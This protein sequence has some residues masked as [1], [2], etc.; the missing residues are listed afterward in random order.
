M[1]A[2][3]SPA[4]V[5]ALL[6]AAFLLLLPAPPAAAEEA[7]PARSIDRIAAGPE[8]LRIRL[9]GGNDRERF[10]LVALH[11]WEPDDAV[12]TLVHAG[13][14]GEET[15]EIPRRLGD[16]DLLFS[17]FLV[18]GDRRRPARWATSLEPPAEGT[19]I[20]WPAARKGVAVPD[21]IDDAVELGSA[22][23]T[24]NVELGSLLL[25]PGAED[26]PAAFI[27]N[28]DG[29]RLRFDPATVRHWDEQ[30]GEMT[31]R[32]LHVT[33]VFLNQLQK[34]AAAK[35]V[36]HP[37]TNVEEALFDLGA[38]NLTDARGVASYTAVL[39]FLAE[40][41]SRADRRYGH[42]GGYIVGNEID[43]HWT[44]HNMGEADLAAVARQ[45]ERE[46]RLAWLAVREHAPGA[47]VFTS[48][49]HSWSRPNARAPLRNTAGREL[50][51]ALTRLSRAGGDFDW[52]IAHHPYPQNLFDPRFWDDQLAMFGFD[53]P[54]ITFANLEL[55]PAFLARPEMLCNG[56][57]RRVI[58]SE[59]GFHTLP[60]VEGERL[61]AAALALAAYRIF[62]IDGIDAFILHRHAD[63]AG[64]G[65]LLLGLRHLAPAP[66]ELGPKKLAWDVFR[67]MET[68]AF[69]SSAAFA[70]PYAGHERW[71]EA[72]PRPGPFPEHAPEWAGFKRR[73]APLVD[74]TAAADQARF[75][76]DLDHGVKL[77]SLPDGGM[78][79][80]LYL[81]PNTPDGPAAAAV[82]AVDLGD[83]EAPE[84]AFSPY[85]AK[86]GSDGVLFRVR[87]DGEELLAA[88][89]RFGSMQEQRVDLSAFAG[90]RV[91]L[92]LETEPGATSAYDEAYF[93]SPAV[94]RGRRSD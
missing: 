23:V 81:H 73:E 10:R 34:V 83:A 13:P 18:E 17:R 85:V 5:A 11:A 8:T 58:L 64:E 80:A 78:A 66:G 49:T 3:V 76:N 31:R 72:A 1:H 48:L 36:I 47:R 59:Q 40:R 6:I 92:R 79:D 93:V 7:A 45:H 51:E 2:D 55:L 52:D 29:Q 20:R 86:P 37:A 39:G 57:P 27:V 30:I 19:Q 75:E 25:P 62:R 53:T 43:S 26:P 94:V 87:V 56:E 46:L 91:E 88:P 67:A 35:G 89:V 90:R 74:L 12:G 42:V 82:F 50:L 69:E 41:Y 44:W 32:G 60:G 9:S 71:E 16:R 38:F 63:A 77:L 70:L 33:V 65:G 54:M 22:H 68:P 21:S 4:R 61:Q 24:V 15:V 84:L 28:R 14:G